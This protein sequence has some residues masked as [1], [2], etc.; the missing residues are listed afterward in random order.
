MGAVEST[1]GVGAA[2]TDS[3]ATSPPRSHCWICRCFRE[4][5]G[6]RTETVLHL[7]PLKSVRCGKLIL[8]IYVCVMVA[9]LII[10]NIEQSPG[11][12]DGGPKY[13]LN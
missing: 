7:M 9:R 5:H 8:V 1:L 13:Y 10:S 6:A 2:R 3:L 4:Q 11:A 12:G